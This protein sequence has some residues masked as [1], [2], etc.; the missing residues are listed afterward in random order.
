MRLSCLSLGLI[1]T[2]NSL[3]NTGYL[4]I[5]LLGTGTGLYILPPD[6]Y[7]YE[8]LHLADEPS[9]AAESRR[10]LEDKKRR[11]WQ[12]KP[13]KTA[14]VLGSYA[15]VWWTLYGIARWIGL[16]VSRRIVSFACH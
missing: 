14:S 10:N 12:A 4:A 2:S 11:A 9:S 3:V 6:P 1:L 7:F 15:V 8:T 5:F 13:G 16:D